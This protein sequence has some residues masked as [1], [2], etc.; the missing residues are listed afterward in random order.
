MRFFQTWLPNLAVFGSPA[1][2]NGSPHR[3]YQKV[4]ARTTHGI[5]ERRFGMTKWL[6]TQRRT[7]AATV[8][9]FAVQRLLSTPAIGPWV[10]RRAGFSPRQWLRWAAQAE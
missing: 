2:T 5:M 4:Q 7:L 6:P 8:I 9:M 1:P 3:L 10:R